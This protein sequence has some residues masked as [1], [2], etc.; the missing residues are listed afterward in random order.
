[1]LAKSLAV[2]SKVVFWHQQADPPLQERYIKAMKKKHLKK[3]QRRDRVRSHVRQWQTQRQ[4]AIELAKLR[5]SKMGSAQ[6][7]SKGDEELYDVLV[8]VRDDLSILHPLRIDKLRSS[9]EGGVAT[10]GCH[11]WNG[12]NDKVSTEYPVV[13]VVGTRWA[14]SA[15]IVAPFCTSTDLCLS[16]STSASYP[17]RLQLPTAC[18]SS[19]SSTDPF[20]T[21]RTRQSLTRCGSRRRRR[22]CRS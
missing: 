14:L 17:P 20:D 22:S 18:F 8:R 4:C 10:L 3:E 1:L 2:A 15:V 7:T 5:R 16:L 9:Y 13:G 12:M 21:S 6:A 11:T 19:H